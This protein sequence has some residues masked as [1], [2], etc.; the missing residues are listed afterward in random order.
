MLKLE[1]ERIEKG[2]KRKSKIDK[3]RILKS[4]NSS[5]GAT[6]KFI[7]YVNRAKKVYKH[8]K[9][10]Q[11]FKDK[12]IEKVFLRFQYKNYNSKN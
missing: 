6:R 11:E 1:K 10:I 2:K 5:K 8:E 3:K 4:L 12:A 7:D 9:Y